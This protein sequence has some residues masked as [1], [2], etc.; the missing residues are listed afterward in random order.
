MRVILVADDSPVSRELVVEALEGI[1]TVLEASDGAEAVALIAA[2][3]PDL[4]LIDIQMPKMDGYAVLSNLR[5]N[6]TTAHIPLVALTAFAMQGDA[7]RARGAG[8]NAYLSKPVSIQALRARIR[9]LLNA[10]A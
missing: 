10:A 8:F 2:H 5:A 4:A 7:D 3:R 1:Y 6:P 9:H